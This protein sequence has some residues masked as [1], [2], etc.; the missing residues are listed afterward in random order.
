MDGLVEVELR[1]HLW[2]ERKVKMQG[3]CLYGRSYGDKGVSAIM[4]ANSLTHRVEVMATRGPSW[5]GVR[6]SRERKFKG[7]PSEGR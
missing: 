2:E 7:R 1:D 5:I 4:A 3:N 6:Q